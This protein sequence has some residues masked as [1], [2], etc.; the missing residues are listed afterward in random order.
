MNTDTKKYELGNSHAEAIRDALE[1]QIDC[2]EK[3][4]QKYSHVLIDEEK[5]RLAKVLRIRREILKPIITILSE[6]SGIITITM[7]KSNYSDP[8]C[9]Q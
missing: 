8:T 9:E 2:I 1:N 5:T 3:R 7:S 4:L 6:S